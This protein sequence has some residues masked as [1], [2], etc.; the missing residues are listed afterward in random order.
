MSNQHNKEIKDK[1]EIPTI[2][3]FE[4]SADDVEHKKIYPT[5]FGW[6]IEKIEVKKM[7]RK[8]IIG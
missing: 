7:E 2:V 8:W 5:L 3:N 6:K 4:I 1:S